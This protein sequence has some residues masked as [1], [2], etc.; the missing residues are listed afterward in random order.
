MKLLSEK[1]A[2]YTLKRNLIHCEEYEIYQYG[3]QNFLEL[4]ISTICSI[5]I[6]FALNMKLEC[7][8]FFCS[9]YHYAHMVVGFIL[10]HIVPVCFFLV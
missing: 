9:L 7:I 6:A 2:N 4:F 8:V 5:I 3:F 10:K 1:M